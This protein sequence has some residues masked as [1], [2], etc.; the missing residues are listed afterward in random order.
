[1]DEDARRQQKSKYQE[2][3]VSR[4][5]PTFEAYKTTFTAGGYL[6][7]KGYTSPRA[8]TIFSESEFE[9]VDQSSLTPETAR[10][11]NDV[12]QKLLAEMNGE[13]AFATWKEMAEASKKKLEDY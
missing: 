6:K 8:R 12:L 11:F 2:W 3:V 4:C 5:D 9:K 7:N 13:D 10:L 1:L